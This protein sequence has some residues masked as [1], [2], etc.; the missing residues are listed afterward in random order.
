M[1]T[2]PRLEAIEEAQKNLKAP[3]EWPHLGPLFSKCNMLKTSE[4]LMY[5]GPAGAYVFRHLDID[6][7]IKG[8]MISVLK[9]MHML[10]RKSSTPGDRAIIRKELPLAV[11][12]L[13]LSLPVYV[14]TF[15]MHVLV[16]H[17]LDQLEAGGPFHVLNMLDIE[18]YD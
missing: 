17:L 4:L 10:M 2:K 15:V 5:A 14:Q 18:R 8:H 13:E 11:T 6:P 12:Q 9:L 1:A 7:S 16:H 3:K